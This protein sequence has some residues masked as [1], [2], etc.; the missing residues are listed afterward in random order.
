MVLLQ[1]LV[2]VFHYLLLLPHVQNCVHVGFVTGDLS[3]SSHILGY[4]R[5]LFSLILSAFFMSFGSILVCLSWLSYLTLLGNLDNFKNYAHSV[6]FL[7]ESCL[8]EVFVKHNSIL[9][10]WYSCGP[11]CSCLKVTILS[12]LYVRMY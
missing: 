11:I 1:T 10:F 8:Q 4:V 9:V 7:P 5:L 12:F 3:P 2:S 6:A